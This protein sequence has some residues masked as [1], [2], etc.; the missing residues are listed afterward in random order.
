M[1]E[2]ADL[3]IGNREYPHTDSYERGQEAVRLASR[4]AAGDIRPVMH[5]VKPPLLIPTIGTAFDPI[6][7]I[8]TYCR[9]AEASS[10]AL[11]NCTFY[12]GFPYADIHEAG[13]AVLVI[14]N[15]DPLLAEKA[16]ETL[17]AKVME[18]K[19]LFYPKH[20]SPDEGIELALQSG[21]G[22]IVLNETSDNPGAGTPGDGTYLLRAMLERGLSDACFAFIYDPQTA[23]QAHAAGAGATID[24]RLGGKTDDL[25][26]APLELRAYVKALT[27]GQFVTTSPMGKG[28][29]SNLGK[30]VRLQVKGLDI[31][32]CSVRNQVFDEQIFLLHGIDVHGKRIIGL[33]S[34]HHFRAAFDPLC[35]RIITVDS[36]GLSM[37]DFTAFRYERVRMPIYPLAPV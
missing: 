30:S 12:H 15:D 4:M 31:I 20:P 8:N 21:A 35:E 27:D 6:R 19:P 22:P 18:H 3:L 9:E 23:E 5:L 37:F 32:V 25:H 26:G 17:A 7:T 10:E 16:A 33:K 13:I 2:H 14:A 1:V 34:S 11:L 36:P 29:R 24:I 28:T